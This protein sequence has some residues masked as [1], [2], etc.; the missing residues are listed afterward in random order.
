M[1][2]ILRILFLFRSGIAFEHHFCLVMPQVIGVVIMRQALTIISVELIKPL[3]VRVS[4][5]AGR[6][7]PP[8][9]KSTCDISRLLQHFRHRISI[10]RK[11]F[12]TLRFSFFISPDIGMS[13]MQT[14]HQRR[15]RGGTHRT[16][17]VM[18]GKQH[19]VSRQFVDI[20]CLNIFL[21]VTTHISVTEIIS[22]NI[23]DVRLRIFCSGTGSRCYQH[24]SQPVQNHFCIH[25]CMID[26]V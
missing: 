2:Q 8:F 3:F 16:P 18:L 24:R 6:T 7:Q 17:G 12:L 22:K 23:N 10:F 20:G 25:N 26:K 11:R 15:T 1:D 19:S 4:G 5:T 9:T 13:R 14:S 21:P